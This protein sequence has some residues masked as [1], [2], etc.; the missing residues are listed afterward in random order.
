MHWIGYEEPRYWRRTQ[1]ESSLNTHMYAREIHKL[2]VPKS[3]GSPQLTSSLTESEI[4]DVRTYIWL[5]SIFRSFHSV[6][7]DSTRW[8]AADFNLPYALWRWGWISRCRCWQQYRKNRGRVQN[9][10]FLQRG[11][12]RKGTF[13]FSFRAMRHCLHYLQQKW[14]D[15]LKLLS[16]IRYGRILFD[17]IIDKLS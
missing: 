1:V 10:A 17:L 16:K 15:D 8:N 12:S 11:Q 13:S 2:I 3:S 6:R 7:E 14:D 4:C 9:W 5:T